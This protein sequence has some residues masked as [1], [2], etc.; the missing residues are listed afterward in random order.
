MKQIEQ[1]EKHLPAKQKALLYSLRAHNWKVTGID[2]GTQDWALEEK[3][4]IESTAENIGF[5]IA[6]WI[7]KYNG[8]HDGLDRVVATTINSP[9]PDPYGGK[10]TLEFDGRKFESPLKTFM[11]SLHQ[12]RTSEENIDTQSL[13]GS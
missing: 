2:E 11:E 8:V 10:I 3:W 13:G 9:E 12:L 5:Q 6:L 1:I 4:V 7:F